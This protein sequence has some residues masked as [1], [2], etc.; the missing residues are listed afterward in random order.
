MYNYVFCCYV[1]SDFGGDPFLTY[2]PLENKSLEEGLQTVLEQFQSVVGNYIPTRIEHRLYRLRETSLDEDTMWVMA[3]GGKFAGLM[4]MVEDIGS[5]GVGLLDLESGTTYLM[6]KKD[7]VE[8]PH[9]DF[10]NEI[11]TLDKQ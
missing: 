2:V 8:I 6:P 1:E 10:E 9:W 3:R 4:G 11:W 5:T 7:V